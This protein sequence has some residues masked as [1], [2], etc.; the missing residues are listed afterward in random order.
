MIYNISISI[1][2]HLEDSVWSPGPE[3]LMSLMSFMSLSWSSRCSFL[4]TRSLSSCM[5]V[6]FWWRCCSSW[7]GFINEAWKQDKEK[8]E[9]KIF[10][11][12]IS[13]LPTIYVYKEYYRLSLFILLDIIILFQK[14]ILLSMTKLTVGK[15]SLKMQYKLHLL[16]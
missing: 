12:N 7:I 13:T 8:L 16:D 2:P 3:G 9:G 5:R 10:R 1:N 11:K 4:L 6:W 14:I 15:C